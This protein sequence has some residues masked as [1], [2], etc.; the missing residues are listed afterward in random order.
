MIIGL[1]IGIPFIRNYVSSIVFDPSKLFTANTNGAW[2]DPSDIT[3]YMSSLGPELVTNGDFSGGATG[4]SVGTNWTI[5]EGFASHATG[6]DGYLIQSIS[7]KVVVGK[8]YKITSVFTGTAPILAGGNLTASNTTLVNGSLYVIASGT[9]LAIY[10]N[11][12]CSIDSISV[13]ELTDISTATLF[14]DAAGTTPVTAVG[15]PVGL[16]LDKSKG[17]V[18]GSELINNS[19]WTANAGWSVNSSTGVATASA[20]TGFI[21]NNGAGGTVLTVGKW[22]QATIRLVSYV[23]GSVGYPYD[24][25]GLV[26]IPTTPGTYTYRFLC[27]NPDSTYVYGTAFTGVV[28]NISVRELPGNHAYNPSGNSAN[29]P[30]LS[31]RYNLL[32]KTE[33]FSDSVWGKTSIAASADKLIPSV[34]N[35][36]HFVSQA[37]TV[38]SSNIEK[39]QAKAD[40]YNWIALWSNSTQ[41]G[42]Y[43]NVATGVVGNTSAGVTASIAPTTD[44]WFECTV[45]RTASDLT[46]YQLFVS[47]SNGTTVF[48]GDG[49]SG[50]RFR[51][52]D[53]RVANDALNQPTYQ[54]VNTATDYDTV[55]FK[56][57]LSFNGVNQWLQT[58]SIDFTYGDKMFVAAGVRKL[59]DAATGMLTELS[60]NLNA[61]AGSFYVLAPNTSGANTYAFVTNGTAQAPTI[62]IGYGAPITNVFAAVGNISGPNAVMRVNGTQVAQSTA[63]Q[64][65]GNYGNYPLYIGARAGSS[66][67]FNGRLYGLV[68]AGKQASA[69]EIASTESW[70]NQK[71]GA[72]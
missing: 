53:L 3:R 36:A 52:P 37:I 33:D 4:W 40:G 15:Q 9:S 68:V 39:V 21:R 71:T 42:A 58:N 30:V 20:V 35:T 13:R 32:T 56:P 57:Y 55:G 18:L 8:T 48:V 12:S 65:T 25:S 54:R 22:Y 2:Y 28:D 19:A 23:S 38:S 72:F 29:F 43:F 31:A 59:S 10:S 27:D 69:G 16:M 62:G 26:N 70:L 60:V 41:S 51:K 1:G 7:G 64:G 47:N 17:L 6:A 45:S 66:L 5:S 44:G 24:G 49:V 11:A 61:N 46:Q 50:V 34:S 14:Q 63:S 67:F